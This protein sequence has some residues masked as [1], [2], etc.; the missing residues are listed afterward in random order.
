VW[1][2]TIPGLPC[3]QIGHNRSIAWGVTAA[4]CD[5]LELYREKI[6]RFEPDRY[7]AD[8]QW[9][10]MTSR[11]ETIGVRRQGEI[12]KTVR[13]TCHGPVISDFSSGPAT[14]V[15]SMRW[16]AHEATEE[17]RCVYGVNRAR[18]WEEFLS[19]LRF[20]TAPSLNYVYADKQGNIGYSLAGKIP[21]HPKIPSLLPLDG[22]N[23]DNEWRGYIPFDELPR[24]Y[25]PP[26]GVIATANNQIT[27]SAYPHYL[28][29]FYDPP[30]RISR[31]KQLLAAKSKHTVS[32]MAAI[33][34]DLVSIHA[35]ESI[36][37]LNEDL[38]QIAADDPQLG[39]AAK[40]L[41]QWDGSCDEESSE[42]AIFH[43]FTSA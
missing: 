5:D 4:V 10:T 16:T 1:G 26:E 20:Q 25:N 32:D 19:G 41:L 28:S 22:W 38:R 34:K 2:G 43:V 8:H 15:L 40:G 17:L 3:V 35:V 7:L 31:I 6:H 30:Y 24:L 36:K 21:L 39:A 42:S 14:E 23:P 29:H 11:I 27:D 37:T 9:L 18:D 12:Q 13:S 33:Q